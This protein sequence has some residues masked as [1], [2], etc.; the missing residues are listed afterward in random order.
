MIT[1]DAL[2]EELRFLARSGRESL[3][4]VE[5]GIGELEEFA[6]ELDEMYTL[7]QARDAAAELITLEDGTNPLIGS[8]AIAMAARAFLH[9]LPAEDNDR[10]LDL[11]SDLADKW[12]SFSETLDHS[13]TDQGRDDTWNEL[14]AQLNAVADAICPGRA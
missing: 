1:P 6:S 12:E 2:A 3:A 14:S 11:I 4:A 8:R 13:Y 10:V 9:A 5:E 7:E